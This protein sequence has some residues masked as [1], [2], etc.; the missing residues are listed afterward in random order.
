MGRRI[1]SYKLYKLNLKRSCVLYLVE[2]MD[3]IASKHRPHPAIVAES[4][5]VA[6]TRNSKYP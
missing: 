1:R 2:R 6:P 5:V 4:A 3:E